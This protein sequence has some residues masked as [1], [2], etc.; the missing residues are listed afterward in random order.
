MDLFSQASQWFNQQSKSIKFGCGCA[1]LLFAWTA[2]MASFAAGMVVANLAG[3]PASQTSDPGPAGSP[4]RTPLAT[5]TRQ[6]AAKPTQPAR[7]SQGNANGYSAGTYLVGKELE[8]GLYVGLAGPSI[9][10][11]CYWA[12]LADLSG[13]MDGIVQNDYA[14]GQFYIEVLPTDLAVKVA[15]PFARWQPSTQPAQPYPTSIDAGTYLVGIEVA[16]GTYQGQAGTDLAD[17]CYWARLSDLTG[18]LESVLANDNS[19]G[20]FYISVEAT[21]R[22]LM[23]ACP[24]EWIEP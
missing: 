10:D 11:S 6:P 3:V 20:Q 23:A 15:C 4:T 18:S 13:T 24:L 14:I 1:M 21:D 9:M 8:P 5:P 7:T 16:P 19:I 17:S 22:A 2:C 12:R